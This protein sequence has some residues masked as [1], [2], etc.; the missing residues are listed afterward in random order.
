MLPVLLNLNGRQVVVVGGG[1]VGRRKAAAARAAGASVRVI[2]PIPR[3]G[4]LSD[5]GL[6]WVTAP[7]R[8]EHLDGAALAF[9]AATPA[10]NAAVVAD[11][12]AR[13]VWVNSATGDGDVFLPATLSVGGLTVAVGTG[14]ATPALARRVRDRLAGQFGPAYADWVAVLDRV[15]RLA[16]DH[17]DDDA[18][19]RDLLDRFADW[20]WLE[21]IR[22]EGPDAVFAAMAE[23][24][25]SQI[26]STKSQPDQ[27]D[28][29]P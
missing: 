24:V 12:R 18:A 27:K 19:R 11:A 8:P 5:P 10:V 28:P 7:Y 1:S 22:N 26:P 13:G 4:D 17:I 3:P 15:R 25:K 6:E 16:L 14:G 29:G 2:D 23:I 20:P 9:A 21:R